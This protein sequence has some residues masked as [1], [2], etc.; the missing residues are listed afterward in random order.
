MSKAVYTLT[1]SDPIPYGTLPV[2][3]FYRIPSDHNDYYKDKPLSPTLYDDETRTVINGMLVLP[4]VRT[5][6]RMQ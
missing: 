1:P 6:A 3:S 5:V 4:L 2:G